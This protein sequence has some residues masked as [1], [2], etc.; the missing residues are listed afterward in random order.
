MFALPVVFMVMSNPVM[1]MF[2]GMLPM[3][4]TYELIAVAFS[5]VIVYVASAITAFLVPSSNTP[6]AFAAS[7]ST[8]NPVRSMLSEKPDPIAVLYTP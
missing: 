3:K 7:T 6:V 1:L 4:S 5:P 2:D 8:F